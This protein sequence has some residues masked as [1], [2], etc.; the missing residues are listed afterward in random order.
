MRSM[1]ARGLAVAA[2]TALC[3]LPLGAAA[4]PHSPP[5][6]ATSI[7]AEPHPEIYAAIRALERAKQH[8]QR[9]AHDFGGHRVEAIQAIDGALVQL[10][11]ALQYDKK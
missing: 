10:R 11:L 5:A 8:L 2:L 9:A 1:I 3:T 6:H 4:Q 7:A